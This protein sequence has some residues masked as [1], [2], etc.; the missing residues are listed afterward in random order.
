MNIMFLITGLG[1]GG[2]ERQVVDLADAL[3]RKGHKIQIVYLTG[4]ADLLPEEEGISVIALGVV[5]SI[6]GFVSAIRKFAKLVR[7]NSP[8]VV[9][10]H[11]VHAN[12]VARISRVLVGMPK[13]IC[14]AHNSNEGGKFRMLAYRITDGLADITT[15]VSQEAADSLLAKGAAPAGR[16]IFVPNG[17]DTNRY[18]FDLDLRSNIRSK[19]LVAPDTVII[20]AVGRLVDA[21]DYPC[22][23]DAF[24]LIIKRRKDTRLWIVGEGLQHQQL[25]T[26]AQHINVSEYVTFFGRRND[27]SSFYCASDIY[28]LSSAWEGFGLV[29]AEAM[30]C[31]RLVVATDCGGVKEV[32]GDD[33]YLVPANNPQALADGIMLAMN[34]DDI[35]KKTL[36]LSARSRVIDNYSLDKV[37]GLWEQLYQS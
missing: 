28:A 24:S 13:L 20:L 12:L 37:V 3:Y 10:S 32:L 1:V 8:D 29:V 35:A 2:A 5:K 30:S 17:I 33:G 9:H 22:L 25:V 16:I 11:M 36:G 14:T 15:N 31:E 34:L 7:L 26:Y 23:L 18:K 21:K 27:V 6:F 19:N 4:R